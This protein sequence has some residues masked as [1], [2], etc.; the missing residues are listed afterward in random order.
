MSVIIG[1]DPHKGPHAAAAVNGGEVAVAEYEV[2]AS[3]P[4]RKR[5][6]SDNASVLKK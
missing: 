2:R 3:T 5:S 1:I 6:T 4:A